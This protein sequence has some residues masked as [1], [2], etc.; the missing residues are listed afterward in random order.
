MATSFYA[1]IDE[2][3]AS[4]KKNSA[5][6]Q[7]FGNSRLHFGKSRIKSLIWEQIQSAQKNLPLRAKSL[8]KISRLSSFHCTCLPQRLGCWP[9]A[10]G[11]DSHAIWIDEIQGV[12]IFETRRKKQQGST[13][14][15]WQVLIPTSVEAP[16]RV[17]FYLFLIIRLQ[18]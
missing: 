16:V 12:C 15:Q 3:T 18:S 11:N 9:L 10:F 17:D 6:G 8:L 13:R 1:Q 5:F 7:N 4:K 2:N 14:C